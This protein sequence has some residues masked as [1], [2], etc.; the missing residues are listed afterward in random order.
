MTEERANLIVDALFS[1][2]GELPEAMGSNWENFEEQ[3]LELL[4]QE[5]PEETTNTLVALQLLDILDKFE[6]AYAILESRYEEFKTEDESLD[7]VIIPVF[8]GTDRKHDI[9]AKK[10]KQ[11]YHLQGTGEIHYGQADIKVDT[12]SRWVDSILPNWFRPRK[13]KTNATIQDIIKLNREEFTQKASSNLNGLESREALVFIHGYNVS[14]ES[15][16]RQT[17]QLAYDIRFK[18]LPLLFSWPSVGALRSYQVDEATILWTQSHNNFARF[19]KNTF[20]ELNLEVIHLVG[21]SMGNRILSDTLHEN[22][23]D[24]TLGQ[25][26]FAAPDVDSR[27]FMN[28]AKTFPKSTKRYTMYASA[29][30]LAL[31]V[32]RKIHK[33][34]RAG[35]IQKG[36]NITIAD[37]VETI[38][39]STQK[40][41]LLGH[42]YFKN[43][44]ILANDISSLIKHNSPPTERKNLFQRTD[45]GK[46]YWIFR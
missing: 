35:W 20:E 39:A 9:H 34:Q 29:K 18:G 38:D 31:R 15:A 44:L 12:H 21:H 33:Y 7:A 11:F 6:Q 30:D 26:I 24:L 42:S 1:V 36:F 32:S 40:V 14:F 10:E 27:V 5:K 8:F 2:W 46:I 41:D 25:V 4:A 45:A 3:V 37:S 17:A 23:L 19:I 13:S 22:R 43:S 16:L 28:R